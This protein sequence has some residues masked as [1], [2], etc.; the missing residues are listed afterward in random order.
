MNWRDAAD[1]E[2]WRRIDLREL[3]ET[4]LLELSDRLEKIVPA[5]VHGEGLF[6]YRGP[7]HAVHINDPKISEAAR[8][9]HELRDLQYGLS[10]YGST[11]DRAERIATRRF[12]ALGYRYEGLRETYLYYSPR[13][14]RWMQVKSSFGNAVEG[15]RKSSLYAACELDAES[16]KRAA[17]EELVKWELLYP[18]RQCRNLDV[19]M[20]V[21]SFIEGSIIFEIVNI[22]S[23]LEQYREH[24]KI[25]EEGKENGDFGGTFVHVEYLTTASLEIGRSL[26]RLIF[27]EHEGDA[28][29]GKKILSSA[30][31]GGKQRRL[32]ELERGKQTIERMRYL[33]T[34][35][36]MSVRGAAEHL[37]RQGFAD[38]ADAVRQRWYRRPRNR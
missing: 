10:D 11:I 27:K 35:R 36:G 25:L 5:V 15:K 17:I 2:D 13:H 20:R 33:T 26:S 19:L 4:E 30:S 28:I 12:A 6:V 38:S 18:W 29:R 37:H 24:M 16:E 7:Q 32:A 3:D 23:W 22:F 34:E 9:L 21:H 31:E 8:K 14:S 1:S